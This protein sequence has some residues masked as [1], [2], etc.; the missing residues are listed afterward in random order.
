MR[1]IYVVLIAV[2]VLAQNYVYAAALSGDF[3]GEWSATIVDSEGDYKQW[4]KPGD[5]SLV[6]ISANGVLT[7]LDGGGSEIHFLLKVRE[8]S[9]VDGISNQADA[10]RFIS[11]F[12][13]TEKVRLDLDDQFMYVEVQ[14][15]GRGSMV[16]I[17]ELPTMI[18]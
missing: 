16:L 4:Y 15:P 7:T 6:F 11:G 17:L 13:K 5:T 18:N 12:N 14:L 3:A 8:G 9:A 1:I 10:E 2:C